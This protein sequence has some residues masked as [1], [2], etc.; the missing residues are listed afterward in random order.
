MCPNHWHPKKKRLIKGI[1][2]TMTVI[3]FHVMLVMALSVLFPAIGNCLQPGMKTAEVTVL[4][5]K[6]QLKINREGESINGVLFLYPPMGKKATYHFQG[7]I[8]GD[9]VTAYHTDGHSFSGT[10]NAQ[11]GKVEGVLTTKKGVKVP[12][13]VP[14]P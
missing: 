6:A 7:T 3:L 2:P 10:I 11:T 13:S 12:L 4:G 1:V 5:H 8:K 9:K 14:V